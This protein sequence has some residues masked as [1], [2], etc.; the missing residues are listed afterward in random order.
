MAACR[1]EDFT[2]L[3]DIAKEGLVLLQE[4]QDADSAQEVFDV[5]GMLADVMASHSTC[6]HYLGWA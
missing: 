6:E 1:L 3:D 4:L 5:M 2:Q